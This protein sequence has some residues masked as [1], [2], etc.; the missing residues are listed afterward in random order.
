MRD[1]LYEISVPAALSDPIMV[2]VM[3]QLS[4]FVDVLL[5]HDAEISSTFI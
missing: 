1:T 5:L 3:D 2:K 4:F